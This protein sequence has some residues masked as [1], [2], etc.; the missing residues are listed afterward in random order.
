[1]TAHVSFK[2]KTGDMTTSAKG[3]VWLFTLI[4]FGWVWLLWIPE[5]LIA[6]GAWAAPA[7]IQQLLEGP[8][9]G[10]W[11]PLIAAALVTWQNC[12]WSGGTVWSQ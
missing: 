8:N 7:A 2:T 6:Q 10:G 3:S 1:M 4:A 12:H 11:G 9:P 5:A